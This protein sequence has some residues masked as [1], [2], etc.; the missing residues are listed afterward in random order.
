[1]D[2]CDGDGTFI[3]YTATS[4]AAD[5]SQKTFM[6]VMGEDGAIATPNCTAAGRFGRDCV[7]DTDCDDNKAY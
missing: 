7:N 3:S 1:M 5:V 4:G 2:G 6:G